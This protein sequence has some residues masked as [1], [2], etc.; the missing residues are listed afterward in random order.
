MVRTEKMKSSKHHIIAA[1]GHGQSNT[2]LVVIGDPITASCDL[3]SRDV[4][5]ARSETRNNH[6]AWERLLISIS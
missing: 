3:S 4:I 6:I 2:A 1:Q 5:V